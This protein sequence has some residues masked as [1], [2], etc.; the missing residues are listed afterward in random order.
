[1]RTLLVLTALLAIVGCSKTIHEAGT[2]RSPPIAAL[3]SAR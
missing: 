2:D 3:P 1:M